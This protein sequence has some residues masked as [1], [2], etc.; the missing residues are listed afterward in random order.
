MSGL[1]RITTCLVALLLAM[2]ASAQDSAPIQRGFSS[3]QL[4]MSFQAAREALL[5]D[6]AFRYRGEPDVQ[7][8]PASEVPLIETEGRA[9]VDRG[10]LQFHDDRL[11]VISLVLD[12]NRLDYFSVYT[13]LVD[14]Y[15]EP[16]SLDPG[17][18]LWER[19]GTRLTLERPLTVKY[20][21]VPT[22][23]AIIEAG[24]TE[25]ALDEMTRDRFLEQL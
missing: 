24:R 2:S 18:S 14:Q 11:D 21:D 4:G 15:G 6:Q 22:L 10:I 23:Q 13:S 12:R 5:V 9:F 16:D 20:I 7:F 8:L 17:R 25:E 1:R 19:E 3:V